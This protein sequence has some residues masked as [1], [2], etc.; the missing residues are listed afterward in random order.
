MRN[1][2]LKD[3]SEVGDQINIMH[4][5]IWRHGL[6]SCQHNKRSDWWMSFLYL[7]IIYNQ[8]DVNESS[9]ANMDM[10]VEFEN[11]YLEIIL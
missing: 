7:N 4:N 8:N 10:K 3:V 1:R 6:I 11:T 2:L 9:R 5:C